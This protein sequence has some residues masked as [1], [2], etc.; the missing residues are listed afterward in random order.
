MTLRD[1]LRAIASDVRGIPQA[2]GLRAIRVWIRASVRSRPALLTGGTVTTTD[3]EIVPRPAVVAIDT[4]DPS[5][6][7][8]QAAGLVGGQ[9]LSEFYQIGPVTPPH[10]GGGY[11][12]GDLVPLTST[13][14]DASRILLADVDSTGMLGT[15]PVEFEL[16]TLKGQDKGRSFRWELLVRRVRANNNDG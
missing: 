1:D 11:S 13:T 12:F 8:A 15:T 7:G 14:T 6:W 10:D 4:V 16:V 3:V 9:A 5:Y 2:M